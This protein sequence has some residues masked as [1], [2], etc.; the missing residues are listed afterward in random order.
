[1]IVLISQRLVSVLGAARNVNFSRETNTNFYQ[2]D[3]SVN[4]LANASKSDLSKPH[5]LA[6]TV[7]FKCVKRGHLRAKCLSNAVQGSGK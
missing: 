3:K 7:C 2:R 6:D 5:D 4:F 1:M